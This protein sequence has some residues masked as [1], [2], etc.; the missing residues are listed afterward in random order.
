VMVGTA[1]TGGAV[2]VWAAGAFGGMR[3]HNRR[4]CV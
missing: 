1:W 2:P 4:A 3:E